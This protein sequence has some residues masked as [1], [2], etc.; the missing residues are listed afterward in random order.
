MNFRSSIPWRN[1]IRFR[2]LFWLLAFAL[3]WQAFTRPALAAA[4]QLH[5]ISA[6]PAT[7]LFAANDPDTPIVP[8]N[9]SATIA[10]RTTGGDPTRNWRVDVQATGGGTLAN[11][12]RSIPLSQIRVTCVSATAA[13]GGTGACT[14][15]FNLS[16]SL[17][18]IA[19]GAEGS[20]NAT[21]YTITVNFSFQDSWQYIATNSPCTVSLS[22]QIIAN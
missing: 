18:M 15:P 21:P 22:Y 13:N 8:G 20:G 10:F 16:N 9:V 11:C 3:V 4:T 7:I 14:A 6:T 19:S 17:Q 1:R 12:P 2:L 5:T